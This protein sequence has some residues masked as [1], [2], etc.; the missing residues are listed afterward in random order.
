MNIC[1]IYKITSPSNKVYIGQ[2]IDIIKRW[3]KYYSLNCKQQPK[4]YASLKK[5]GIDKHK[6]EIICQCN[7]EDLN[8]LEVFYIE[9]Y[10]SFNDNNGLNLLSGG[11]YNKFSNETRVK[12]SQ[13]K[14]GVKRP[15]ITD[16]HRKN[17]SKAN[18]GRL[19]SEAHKESLRKSSVDK[20]AKPIYQ[21]DLNN[22]VIKKWKSSVDA[23]NNLNI[24][25]SHISK[26][27]RGLFGFKSAGGF[28][29]KYA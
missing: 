12:M 10:Q 17:L 3:K 25:S 26:C 23:Q 21:L 8:K 13:A 6:F 29:W 1:G 28:K 22:V 9:T 7:K 20:N 2:S 14:I 24:S 19:L 15:P 27:C 11:N 5:H 16:E 4:I 18:K